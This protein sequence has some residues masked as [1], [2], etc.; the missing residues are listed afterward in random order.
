MDGIK[1]KGEGS[2]REEERARVRARTSRCLPALRRRA[3][4]AAVT[5]M[6]SLA[7]YR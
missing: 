5:T 7:F 4:S 6:A 3:G 1:R 2:E